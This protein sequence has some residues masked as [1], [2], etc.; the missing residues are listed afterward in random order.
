MATPALEDPNFYRTVLLMLE[1]GDEGALGVVLNRPSEM[2]L[3]GPVPDWEPFAAPPPVIF[4]GGPVAPGTAI[5]L[6]RSACDEESEGWIRLFGRVGALDIG[7]S[8]PDVAQPIDD[9][10]VFSGHAGWGPGQLEGEIAEGAWFVVDADP[11]DPLSAQPLELWRRVL[12]RQPCRLA[13]SSTFP[14]A[15]SLN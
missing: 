10:R 3:S 8:P 9:I 1:H 6:A 14:P 4:F 13:L 2:E 12:L 7:R 15:P 5:C 11:D